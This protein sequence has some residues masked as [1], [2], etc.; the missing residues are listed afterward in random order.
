MDDFVFNTW[1]MILMAYEIADRLVD[2]FIA[3]NYHDGNITNNPKE[4]VHKA[5]MV[6]FSFALPVTVLRVF[7]YLHRMNL[8]RCGDDCN[9]KK[10]H[11][12]NMWMS[13]AKMLFE[14]FPQATIALFYFGDCAP[15]NSTKTAVQAFNT[16]SIFPFIMSICYAVFYFY[17]HVE[18]AGRWIAYSTALL[19]QFLICLTGCIFA[20]ISINNFNE[21]CIEPDF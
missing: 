14:A 5:L 21:P 10:H 3:N 8:Y 7:L 1:H 2:L 6:I 9:D 15:T 19:T 18:M 13:W 12:I 17:A 20:G 16:F 11:A 4:S